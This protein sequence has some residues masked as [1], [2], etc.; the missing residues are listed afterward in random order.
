MRRSSAPWL[1][2]AVALAGCS[3]WLGAGP[4]ETTTSTAAVSATTTTTVAASTTTTTTTTVPRREPGTVPGWSVGEP[5]GSVEGLT[6][7]RGNPTRTYYGEPPVPTNP[8]VLW[9]YPIDG[10]MCSTSSVSG[11]KTTWCG[12]GWTGQ[13]VVYERSDGVTEVI[14]GAYDK[15]V[16]FLN[17]ST[18]LPTRPPFQ[19]GDLI[20]G[21]VSLDP[22]GYPLLYFGSRD[23]KL[24]IVALDRPE[25]E[26]LW[27]LDASAV[28]GIWNNDWDGN[29][30]I[31]DDLL[32]EGGENSWFFIIKLNRSYGPDG[33]VAVAPERLVEIPGYTN[34]LLAQVGSNVSIENSPAV[35]DNRV[36]FANSGGR[37]VGLDLSRVADGE[38]PIVFDYW[39]GDDVDATITIDREGMLYVAAELERFNERSNE[40]GQ[41]IKLDPYATDPYVWGVPVPP[42]GPGDGGI[43]ATPALGDGVLYASTHPGELLAI[44]TDTGRVLWR[45][46]IGYHAWS[47][48]VIVDNTLLVS[49]NCETGGGFRAYSLTVPA[50]PARLWQYDHNSGCIESTPAV[51]K[52]TIYVGSRDG[53]FYALGEK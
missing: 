28:P 43:W 5:W 16:H 17:G 10:P 26:L 53:R 9:T 15:K 22:D 11:T 37:V 40:L 41:L 4:S 48:P 46:E 52:G 32:L 21:S 42:R 44:D 35:F 45:D 29:P 49:V 33:R 39:V 18:G 23:N 14:F 1:V 51:W 36:Y 27:N 24:R 12:T 6:M 30:V 47:S 34:D 31:L 25:P 3:S 13:P 8:E 7:F 50:A 2:V 19:T 20:K 38:A